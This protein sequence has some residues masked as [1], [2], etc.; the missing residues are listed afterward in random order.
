MN[1]DL[2]ALTHPNDPGVFSR[3]WSLKFERP[4]ASFFIRHR[5]KD[6]KG[7]RLPYGHPPW[8]L[9]GWT[10]TRGIGVRGLSLERHERWFYSIEAALGYAQAQIGFAG[11]RAME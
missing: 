7:K 3:G 10:G 2:F 4:G 11:L 5:V 6:A 9:E 1:P 8:L